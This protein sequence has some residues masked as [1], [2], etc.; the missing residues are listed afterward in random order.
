MAASMQPKASHNECSNARLPQTMKAISLIRDDTTGVTPA[1]LKTVILPIPQAKP[2]HL[3]VK[4]CAA[5]IN[6]SD[7][8]NWDGGF[9]YTTYPRV[10][11]RDFAGVVEDGDS[12]W[13]GKKVFGSSGRSISF[14]QDGTHAEY[15][16]IPEGAAV[17][18]PSVL[19]FAQAA[20]IGVPWSTAS[21]MLKRARV[22][23]SDT[24]LVLGACGAVGSSAV[25][26][27]RA[28]A[29][30]VI[31]AA[32][33]DFADINTATDSEL[34]GVRDL[35]SG[36]G[37]D[38][39]IDTVGD[40]A[41]MQNALKVLAVRGRLCF[42]AA[43]RTADALFSFNLKD[44]YRAEHSIVGCNS[45][46]YDAEEIGANLCELI[47]GFE[48]GQHKAVPT[49]DIHT[50]PLEKATEAYEAVRRKDGRKYVIVW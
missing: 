16:Q 33:R 20:C 5:A 50:V 7:V 47:D 49:K 19:S 37:V 27:A 4:I 14:T 10:P 28:K 23:P 43:P 29:C 11:G 36:K 12:W 46:Q 39:V 26:L 18:M 38:V 15:C 9:P 45:L 13:I 35:T 2:G 17:P 8:L 32:R 34:T 41:L 44:L 25:Q 31:T 48:S 22:Q 24:V 1:S 40:P 42:I 3:L 21:I 30:R 6:P